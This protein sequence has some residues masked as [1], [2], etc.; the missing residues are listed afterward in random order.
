MMYAC[1]LVGS[2]SSR[3]SGLVAAYMLFHMLLGVVLF[4]C[5]LGRCRSIG[6]GGLAF[7][8]GADA[9][10][11][12]FFTVACFLA[13]CFFTT[14]L[15]GAALAAGAE[16][17]AGVAAK[18]A[19]EVRPKTALNRIRDSFF[20][21]I[22]PKM[23]KEGI[24]RTP[25]LCASMSCILVGRSTG[26]C[27]SRVSRCNATYHASGQLPENKTAR[28]H[29]AVERAGRPL[30]RRLP[31]YVGHRYRAGFPAPRPPNPCNSG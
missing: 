15:A 13:T 24:S 17:A 12:A 31:H 25:T 26:I 8:A 28:H 3:F 22:S 29:R 16:A 20:M 6:L 14:F 5:G 9:A 1:D 11:L 7:C 23:E 30:L 10:D 4:H 18:P 27:E 2:R 19:A 21:C